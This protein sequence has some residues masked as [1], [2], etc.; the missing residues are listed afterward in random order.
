MIV[1]GF[2]FRAG[3]TC[4]S[5]AD[6]LEKAAQGV[7][8]DIFATLAE[9][10]DDL[11]GFAKLRQMNVI[12]IPAA[13]AEAQETLTKSHASLAHKSIGSVAEATALAA[14]GPDARLTG[15]RQISTDRMATCAIAMGE[16]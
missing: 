9:K 14:A 7:R 10:A 8:P 2:G 4:D 1:A 16:T 11:Q 6:A 12:A 13:Q 3:A 15:P 5:L